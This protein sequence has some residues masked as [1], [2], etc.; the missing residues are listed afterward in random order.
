M[1]SHNTRK[2]FIKIVTQ[3]RR[4]SYIGA[5]SVL[6]N[7]NILIFGLILPSL[8]FTNVL[9]KLSWFWMRKSRCFR[10][11]SKNITSYIPRNSMLYNMNKVTIL[12]NIWKYVS[13]VSYLRHINQSGGNA[14]L[15]SFRSYCRRIRA[16]K[17]FLCLT[18]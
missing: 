3:D 9:I 14:W 7:E 1:K 18:L 10:L 6:V 13:Y 2:R 4:F 8:V 11:H 5:I 16:G 12:C 15:P 17:K